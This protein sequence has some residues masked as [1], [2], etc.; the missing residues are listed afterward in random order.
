[1][2]KSGGFERTLREGKDQK[3]MLGWGG[4]L[5]VGVGGIENE[6][7]GGWDEDEEDDWEKKDDKIAALIA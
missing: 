5:G 1:M 3:L 7:G 2:Y 6:N 4:L